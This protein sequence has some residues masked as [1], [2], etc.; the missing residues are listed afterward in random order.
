MRRAALA[1]L[2]AGLAVSAC[3]RLGSLGSVSGPSALFGPA[4]PVAV[5]RSQLPP[6]VDPLRRGGTV[7]RRPLVSRVTELRVE[8]ASSGAIVTAEGIA[9]AAG[10]FNAQLT[11]IG[12]EG[13]TLVYAFRA[14][15]P[16]SGAIGQRRL[17]SAVMIDEAD[18]PF[19]SSVRVVANE[20]AL[21]AAR[22]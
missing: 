14:E 20:N 7:D 9:P 19:V 16:E 15:I 6:L 11:R 12:F 8:P 4:T 18:L 5:D 22:R 10:A 3:D 17:T 13:G 2:I 21:S 1:I